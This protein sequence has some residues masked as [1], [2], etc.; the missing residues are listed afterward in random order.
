MFVRVR[1]F[2][3]HLTRIPLVAECWNRVHTPMNE[4]SKFCILVPFWH[5]VMRERLPIRLKRTDGGLLMYCLQ[6][7]IAL[8]GEFCARRLPHHVD[9]CVVFLCSGTILRRC[10]CSE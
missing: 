9:R 7:F 3:V 2:N 5:L 6:D 4:N 8:F 10:L 1:P